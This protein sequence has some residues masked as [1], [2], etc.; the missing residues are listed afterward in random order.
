MI[1]F[2]RKIR[3]QLADDN[4]PLKYMRYAIGEILLV[5]IGI[6][7]ALQVNNWNQQQINDAKIT[8]ILKEIQQ[9]LLFDVESSKQ[10]FDSFI[11]GCTIEDSILNNKSTRND[12]PSGLK[13]GHRL[14]F[15]TFNF[16]I[17][18]GGYD[19]LARNIDNVPEKY[20]TILKDLKNLYVTLKTDIDISNSRVTEASKK[21]RDYI[22]YQHGFFLQKQRGMV[23]EA[24]FNYYLNDPHYKNMVHLYMMDTGNTAQTSQIFRFKAL[25]TYGKIQELIEST[26]SI[27]KT[28]DLEPMTQTTLNT[29][30]GTYKIMDSSLAV[31]HK[32][33][34]I[35]NEGKELHFTIEEDD[36]DL[37]LEHHKG[38]IFILMP[39]RMYISVNTPSEGNLSMRRPGLGYTTYIKE[40]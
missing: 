32:E 18:T 13:R 14:G 4:K 8:S 2:F 26:D 31:W 23:T 19:N 3:K 37:K 6:L 16:V 30:V 15:D 34:K 39:M 1:N 35:S 24:E 38:S 25:E 11:R 27:P 10:F 5:V 36:I 20:Q 28:L 22:S 21:N 7:I 17:N 40:E 9:D 29:I 33:I 12:Y